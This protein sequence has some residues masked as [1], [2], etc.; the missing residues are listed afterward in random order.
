MQK[1]K[2]RA[3][4]TTALACGLIFCALCALFPPRREVGTT[5]PAPRGFLFSPKIQ[6]AYGPATY[7]D[8]Y[9]NNKFAYKSPQ[10]VYNS[11]HVEIDT[12]H[13][14]GEV[15]FIFSVFGTISLCFLRLCSKPA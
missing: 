12:G 7:P 11:I 13:L 14:V 10:P 5:D 4:A 9:A 2:M 3:G 8:V 6:W 1:I 15:I